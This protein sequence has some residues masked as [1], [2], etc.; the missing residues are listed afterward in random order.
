[1][2]NAA[3]L[4]LLDLSSKEVEPDWEREEIHAGRG[5]GILLRSAYTSKGGY[6]IL[7]SCSP[8][9]ELR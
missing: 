9:T 4:Q 1:M 7:L 3:G 6:G 2:V 8:K 5:A